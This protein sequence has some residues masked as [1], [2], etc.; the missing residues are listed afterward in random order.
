MGNDNSL[1][2]QTPLRKSIALLV[3]L[4]YFRGYSASPIILYSSGGILLLLL[5]LI[6]LEVFSFSNLLFFQE[7]FY[8]SYNSSLEVFD[9]SN[10]FTLLGGILL[11]LTTFNF[12]GG[13]QLLLLFIYSIF[14]QEEFYFS[15]YTSLEVFYFSNLFN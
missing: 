4:L 9:F 5:F 13:I 7:E 2:L 15:Y 12:S 3:I 10:Q 11:L 1:T 14:F 6:F 8:F